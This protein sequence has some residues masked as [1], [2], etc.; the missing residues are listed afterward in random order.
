MSNKHRIWLSPPHMS[1]REMKYL[2]EAFQSNWI[3][4]L[5]PHVDAFEKEICQYLGAPAAAALVSGTAA[6]HLALILLG[7]QA[8]D[9]VLCQSLT[10]S[11]SANPIAY[12]QAR[13]VFIDSESDSWNM[14]PQ[15][16]RQALKEARRNGKKPKAVIGVH[17]YG[18]PARMDEI[19]AICREYE[20]P[21][22]EDAAE[23]LGSRYNGKPVGA[24]SDFGI[25]SFNGNKIITTSGGGML[26]S[27]EEHVRQARFYSTQARD[28]APHYEHSRIGYNYR[29]SNV[30]AGIGRGQLEVLDE[31]VR[32]KRAIFEFYQRAL[33]DLPGF[34]FQPE[35]PGTQS[36]RWLTALTIDPEQAGTDRET[37]RRALVAENID[38]RPL[39]KPMHIQPV[40]RDARS[41]TNEVSEKLFKNGLCL[42]SG[43]NL[44]RDDLERISDIIRR[45]VRR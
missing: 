22:I 30:L 6:I 28:E 39:W 15:L 11:G 41:Y 3:A 24:L 26:I 9:E 25:L 34:H 19:I 18:Q 20:V 23:A 36:N 40:F 17:L 44:G 32:Q 5:G 12:Q 27:T 33:G 37:I 21:L 31:R 29:L 42:P 14:D 10:F 35:L 2:E 45:C 7:V 4:P 13:P 16:L 1:G 38:S 8:G 43:T